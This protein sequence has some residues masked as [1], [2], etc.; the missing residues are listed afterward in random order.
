MLFLLLRRLNPRAAKVTGV[1]LAATGVALV[2]LSF[3]VAAG[4]LSHGIALAVIG[5]IFW[6]SPAI[7]RLRARS[8]ASSAEKADDA[9]ERATAGRM[10]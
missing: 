10:R 5:A 7:G 1:V 6:A 2:I 4:L 3:A 9:G 8:A